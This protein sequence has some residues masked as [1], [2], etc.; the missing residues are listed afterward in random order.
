MQSHPLDRRSTVR[1]FQ[2]SCVQDGRT[3]RRSGIRPSA[4]RVR[5]TATPTRQRST[6]HRTVPPP[7]IPCACL[8]IVA[9]K[10]AGTQVNG[11]T[12]DP[13]HRRTM[14]RS[15][16]RNRPRMARSQCHSSH[17]DRR[18]RDSTGSGCGRFRAALARRRPAG[19]PVGFQCGQR[20]CMPYPVAARHGITSAPLFARALPFD[21]PAGSRGH[22]SRGHKDLEG[23]PDRGTRQGW[24]ASSIP[25]NIRAPTTKPPAGSVD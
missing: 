17:S 2:G 1:V 4:P 15:S 18:R 22:C 14:A 12:R 24:I 21:H 20:E 5:S 11:W 25:Q 23:K 6:P 10:M 3:Q 19:Y 7:L 9:T 8:A 16:E 13:N